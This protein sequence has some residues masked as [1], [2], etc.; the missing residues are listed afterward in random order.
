[1]RRNC[2]HT[3]YLRTLDKAL[4][5]ASSFNFDNVAVS[6]GFDGHARDLASLS[7]KKETYYEVGLRI[8]ALSKPT[9]FVL[10]GGYS[11]TNLGEDIDSF[12]KGFEQKN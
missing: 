5:D 4:E 10:E 12:L 8:A 6:A 7:L 1:L 11:A 3:V 9:F 2:G